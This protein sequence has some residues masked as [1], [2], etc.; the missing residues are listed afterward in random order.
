MGISEKKDV[1]DNILFFLI[2]SAAITVIGRAAQYSAA[3][4]TAAEYQHHNNKYP[5]P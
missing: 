2:F 3:A 5:Y 4:V 1:G